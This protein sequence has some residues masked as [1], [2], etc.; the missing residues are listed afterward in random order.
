M[1]VV[2]APSPL[3]VLDRTL[4]TLNQDW[5]RPLAALGLF[6]LVPYVAGYFALYAPLI[7][8]GQSY[9]G[10]QTLAY[11]RYY[12]F[13]AWYFLLRAAALCTA[14]RLIHEKLKGNN[15]PFAQMLREAPWLWLRSLPVYLVLSVAV[16]LGQYA[17]VVPGMLA[18]FVAAFVLPPLVLERQSLIGAIRTGWTLCRGRFLIL[19][20]NI[21]LVTGF[22]LAAQWAIGQANTRFSS[23]MSFVAA[24]ILLQA[25]LA[26]V[27]LLQ[28]ALSLS[29]YACARDDSP[30]PQTVAKVF[31]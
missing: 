5:G 3:R 14:G 26:V 21:A 11:A 1:R 17:W 27:Q 22:A 8:A 29:L 20:V 4:D 15:L 12:A 18:S 19:A 10:S 25:A 28:T 31:D 2:L 16:Y 23:G 9:E 7:D 13:I 6:F 30:P 24:S